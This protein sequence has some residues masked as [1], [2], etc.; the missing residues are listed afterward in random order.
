MERNQKIIRI[1]IQGIVVNIILVIFKMAVGMLSNS[2]AIILDAVNNF[3]DALSSV[4]TIVGTKIAAKAPDKKHPFGYGRS[5]YIS[6]VAISLII[7]FAG[8]S[9]LKESLEKV[10]YPESTQYSNITIIII[11][12]AVIVKFVFGQYLKKAGN[13]INAQS[14]VASG[15]DAVMDAFVSLGTLAAAFVN[16]F[17]HINID[18][19]LGAVISIF[20]LKAGLEVLKETLGSII[21]ARIDSQFAQKIKSQINTHEKVHGSYDLVLHDYGP[22]EMIGSVH[23]EVADETTAK[24]IDVLTREIMADIY[25]QFGVLLTVGIYASN[26]TDTQHLDMKKAIE[27]E[28]RNY[29]EILQMHG[30]YVDSDKKFVSFDVV[31]DYNAKNSSQIIGE[32]KEKLGT[33]YKDYKFHIY[34]D[35]DYSD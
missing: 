15:M 21:G 1:S 18:G 26:T 19:I 8:L 20:I 33:L 9:A 16:I 27:N 24:E 17:W 3:S 25:E 12:V 11:A 5:E 13:E 35:S 34:K 32:L 14:L 6:S 30:F 2:I 31:I 7:L 23:I 22:N 29:K 28:I 10:F 4:I